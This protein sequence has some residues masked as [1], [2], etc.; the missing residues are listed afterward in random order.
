MNNNERKHHTRSMAQK[1][2]FSSL[3]DSEHKVRRGSSQSYIEQQQIRMDDQD[4]NKQAQMDIQQSN[5]MM[6]LM[7]QLLA[8]KICF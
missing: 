4:E 1:Q 5:K 2:E 8:N 6:L 7:Q 3:T